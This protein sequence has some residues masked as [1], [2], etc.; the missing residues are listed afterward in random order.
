V[1]LGS[2]FSRLRW[3]TSTHP[4]YLWVGERSLHLG[5]LVGLD[6]R[7]QWKSV[8]AM[9][10]HSTEPGTV[11]LAAMCQALSVFQSGIGTDDARRMTLRVVLADRWLAMAC[12]PWSPVMTDYLAAH[13]FAREY[14]NQLGFDVLPT[15][16]LRLD[17]SAF[18]VARWAVCYPAVLL[19]SIATCADRWNMHCQTIRPQSVLAWEHLRDQK[20]KAMA[21]VGEDS[22]VFGFSESNPGWGAPR[23][24]A[25]HMMLSG[26]NNVPEKRLQIAWQRWCLRY[27]AVQRINEVQVWD[28][29]DPNAIGVVKQPP[30]LPERETWSGRSPATHWLSAFSSGDPLDA[31]SLPSERS[32]WLWALLVALVLAVCLMIADAWNQRSLALLARD[33]PDAARP[34]TSLSKVAP[35]SRDEQSRLLSVNAAIRQLNAPIGDVLQALIPPRDIRVAV[36]SVETVLNDSDRSTNSLKV[37]AEAPTSDD[38]TRYTAFIAGRR[39]FVRAYLIQHDV[40]DSPSERFRFTLEAQ[41]ND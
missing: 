7:I 13:A 14:L 35:L 39:P 26:F 5:H 15:D 29:S 33:A 23:P 1:S 24:S 11:T 8:A 9:E 10:L 4:L 16:R 41:W 12:V 36:L 37:K 19:E 6:H 18:G 22:V 40:Q 21:I 20:T 17:N 28:A 2:G 31:V 38:M 34:V 3:R 30:F 32:V 27:S 25:I